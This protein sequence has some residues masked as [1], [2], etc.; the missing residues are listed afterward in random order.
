[1]A[2]SAME[3]VRV[4]TMPVRT[5]SDPTPESAVPAG[6]PAAQSVARPKVAVFFGLSGGGRAGKV[7]KL[8]IVVQNG[9][10][11]GIELFRHDHRLAVFYLN[12]LQVL[13]ISPSS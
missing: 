12:W 9:F 3:R 6:A 2:E 1:M 8:P 4:G 5:A 11:E 7:T 13:A 10:F